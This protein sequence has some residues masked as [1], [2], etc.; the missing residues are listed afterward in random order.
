M[1]C[2]QFYKPLQGVHVISSSLYV[3]GQT[4][5]PELALKRTNVIKKIESAS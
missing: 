5:K 1:N 4:E 3:K 2:K